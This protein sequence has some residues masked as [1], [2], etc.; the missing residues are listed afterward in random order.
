MNKLKY[1]L[2]VL[3]MVFM[4]TGCF[5]DN[6]VDTNEAVAANSWTYAK[7]AKATIEIK[8]VNQAY[9]IYFKLRNTADYR[10]SN[11]F[12]LAHIKGNGLNKTT[13]YQFKLARADG[14]WLGK[15]SGDIYTSDFSLLTDYRFAKPGKYEIE[16]EQNMRDNPLIGI[17]DIGITVTKSE[18]K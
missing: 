15:G 2:P 1:I 11:L 17:S 12:V 13:R 5:N 6:L 9:D 4:L 10:Y 18:S 14:E 16:I 3:A 7:S 8:D